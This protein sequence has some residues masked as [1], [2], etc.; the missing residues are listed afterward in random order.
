MTAYKMKIVYILPLILFSQLLLLKIIFK[1]FKFIL[2]FC[3]FLVHFFLLKNSNVFLDPAKDLP[4]LLAPIFS[5]NKV[6]F[7]SFFLIYDHTC[8]I[9]STCCYTDAENDV[10]ISLLSVAMYGSIS[11]ENEA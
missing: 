1:K 4:F 10:S 3:S 2:T 9:L 11:S 8:K 6:F 5:I 7:G